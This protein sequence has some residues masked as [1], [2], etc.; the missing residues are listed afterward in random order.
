MGT[1]HNL[2][3]HPKWKGDA[4]LPKVQLSRLMYLK[5]EL[6]E[7]DYLDFLEAALDVDHYNIADEDI[8]NIV[9]GFFG[10]GKIQA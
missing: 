9:D 6:T 4:I 10:E 8:R 7:E 1:I 3:D 5:E 2:C